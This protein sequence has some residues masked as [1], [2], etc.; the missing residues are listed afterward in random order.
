MGPKIGVVTFPGSLDDQDALR[1]IRL[2]G[3]ERCR[4][5]TPTTPSTTYRP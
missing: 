1:A 5:G 3:G 2:C 4:C